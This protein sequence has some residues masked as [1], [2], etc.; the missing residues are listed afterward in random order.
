MIYGSLHTEYVHE[1]MIEGTLNNHT[2]YCDNC[3][4]MQPTDKNTIHE[5]VPD[6]GTPL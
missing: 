5:S 6:R 2:W 1:K 4:S 3:S